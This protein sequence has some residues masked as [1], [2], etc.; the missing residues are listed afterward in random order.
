MRI[1]IKGMDKDQFD[2]ILMLARIG[3]NNCMIGENLEIVEIIMCKD[4]KYG[5]PDGKYGC[6]AYH[7]KLYEQHEMEPDDFCSYAERRKE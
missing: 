2:E 3:A 1:I 7:Y 4:C 6:K 5:S